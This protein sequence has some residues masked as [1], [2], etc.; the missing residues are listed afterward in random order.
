LE[1]QQKLVVEVVANYS[2]AIFGI[3]NAEFL[4]LRARRSRCAIVPF[5]K[6]AAYRAKGS[7]PRFMRIACSPSFVFVARCMT[8]QNDLLSKTSYRLL[9]GGS[10]FFAKTESI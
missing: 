9:E 4:A 7:L 8:A 6:S 3:S 1:G 10:R 5:L 2:K